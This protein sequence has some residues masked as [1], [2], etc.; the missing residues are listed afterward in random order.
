MAVD[1]FLKLDGVDGEAADK[2]HSKQSQ[3]PTLRRSSRVSD[4]SLAPMKSRSSAWES[5]NKRRSTTDGA[6]DGSTG[7]CKIPI[8]KLL[9][10]KIALSLTLL[11]TVVSDGLCVATGMHEV[12]VP[13]TGAILT[14][15]DDWDEIPTN[16][17]QQY[18][19]CLVA[20]SPDP[21]AMRKIADTYKAAYQKRSGSYFSCPYLILITTQDGRIPEYQLKQAEAIAR[22]NKKG[23]AEAERQSGGLMTG[24]EVQRPV[25][26]PNTRRLWMT[27]TASVNG[28]GR[29]SGTTVIVPTEVGKLQL[30]MSCLEADS[31]KYRELFQTMGNGLRATPALAYAPRVNDTTIGALALAEGAKGLTAGL[32]CGAI[33]GG[34]VA[35]RRGRL[36]KAFG[37]RSR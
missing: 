13:G 11:F 8:L 35:L 2:Q 27:A 22:G 1:R 28:V 12:E 5:R 34:I 26:D 30:V 4:I 7:R 3:G 23:A 24:L 9:S 37:S 21:A 15:P 25:Y 20:S 31:A 18:K 16:V 33:A 19:D 6:A 14:V 32:V 29:V 17:L 10:M 36:G